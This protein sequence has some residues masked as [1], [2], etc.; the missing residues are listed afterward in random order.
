MNNREFTE[1]IKER[2]A[3]KITEVQQQND[4][5][6]TFKLEP[7]ALFECA[8]VFVKEKQFRFIIASGLHS[9][10]GF[11]I[12]YH[13]SNDTSGH[14]INL[15]LVLPYE[16][17]AVDSLTDLMSAAEWIEREIH[18]LLGI[19]FKGHPNLV[20]LISEGNWPEGT[21]PYCKDFKS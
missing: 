3:D 15:H 7:E 12:F 18:E 6:L 16:Q 19:N 14:V 20:P 2:F 9:K 10:Q 5:R 17:P 13:F 21:Y 4:M 11:E 1:E 8:Q